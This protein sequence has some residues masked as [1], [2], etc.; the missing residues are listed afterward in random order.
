MNNNNKSIMLSGNLGV[1]I[2]THL[3]FILDHYRDF[4]LAKSVDLMV[5]QASCGIAN[6][7]NALGLKVIIVDFLGDDEFGEIV[8]EKYDD[9]RDTRLIYQINPIGTKVSNIIVSR[10]GTRLMLLDIRNENDFTIKFDE[11]LLDEVIPKVNQMH[12]SLVNWN[13]NLVKYIK[14]KS[15]DVEFSVDIQDWDGQNPY[16]LSFIKHSDIIFVSDTQFKSN[17]EKALKRLIDLGV[18]IVVCTSGEDGS[19]LYTRDMDAL[20]HFPSINTDKIFGASVTDTTGAGDANVYGFLFARYNNYS[21]E[22]CVK[23]GT[24]CAAHNCCF[25]GNNTN[26]IRPEKLIEYYNILT[27]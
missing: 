7:L 8:K 16:H 19:Y 3:D 14:S 11:S 20:R 25:K 4:S 13:I 2:I 5:G 9:N 17:R 26:P 18:K 6:G 21:I 10:D 15:K 27:S 24:I 22:D 12:F 1:E 23:F